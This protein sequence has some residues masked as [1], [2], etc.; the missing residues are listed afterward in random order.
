MVAFLVILFEYV[1]IMFASIK[2]QFAVEHVSVTC[3]C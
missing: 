1:I 2:I 3:S